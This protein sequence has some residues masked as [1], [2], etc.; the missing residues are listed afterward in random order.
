ML[1]PHSTLTVVTFLT[2][3]TYGQEWEGVGYIWRCAANEPGAL[4]VEI[5]REEACIK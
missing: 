2:T 5:K 3:N 4:T 1:R